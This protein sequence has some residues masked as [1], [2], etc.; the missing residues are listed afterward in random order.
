MS[1][2]LWSDGMFLGH[3]VVREMYCDSLSL[4]DVGGQNKGDQIRVSRNPYSWSKTATIIYVDSP[5][6]TGMVR[7][8]LNQYSI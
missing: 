2:E 7:R 1:V 5:V 8:R 4:P 3:I 6:G